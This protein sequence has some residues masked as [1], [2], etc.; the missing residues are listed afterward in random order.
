MLKAMSPLFLGG[1]TA[2]AMK[3]KHNLRHS[4]Q[5]YEVYPGAAIRNQPSLAVH[6]NKKKAPTEDLMHALQRVV[7]YSFEIDNLH[8]F[9]AIVAW[10]IAYRFRKGKAMTAGEKS[11]GIIYY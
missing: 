7:P 1:L 10:D 9:D 8:Q 5:F 6:Y 11:E 4:T 3:L 2:R